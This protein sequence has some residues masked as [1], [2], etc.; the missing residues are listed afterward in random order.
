MKTFIA[1]FLVAIAFSDDPLSAVLR[2]PKATLKLYGDFKAMQHMRFSSSEDLMR[3]RL[4]KKNAHFVAASNEDAEDTAQYALNFF[5]AMTEDE[6]RQWTGVNVTNH[7]PND[8]V[9]PLLTSYLSAPDSRLWVNE[10]A[11]TAVKNQGSCGSCWTF[12][13][14]GGLETHY[15]VKAGRLRNFAEQEY[16]D[17]VY[18]GQ[19]N[20]CNGGWPDNAYYYS[21]NNGGRIA[22]TADYPYRALDGTC[23]ASSKPNSAI[24]YK[25]VGAS[26]IGTS[27]SDNIQALASGSLSMA[28]EVTSKFQ[29][30]SGGIIKDTTCTGRINHGVTGVGYTPTYV[31]VK[32]SWG[33]GWGDHGY[34]KFARHHDNCQ[35]FKYSSHAKL[36]STDLS[37][38]GTDDEATDYTPSDDDSSPQPTCKDQASGC[39]TYHCQYEDLAENYCQET[40]NR[41]PCASEI[42]SAIYSS[43]KNDVVM[44]PTFEG[45]TYRWL[46]NNSTYIAPEHS[47]LNFYSGGKV[48]QIKNLTFSDEASYTVYDVYNTEDREYFYLF[49]SASSTQ[50]C[51]VAGRVAQSAALYVLLPAQYAV[52]TRLEG[53][54]YVSLK[55]FLKFLTFSN[56]Q[57]LQIIDLRENDF[58]TY[59]AD[60]IS[61]EGWRYTFLY[62]LYQDREPPTP[63][64]TIKGQPGGRTQ[65]TATTVGTFRIISWFYF[66]RGSSQPTLVM[67]T[68]GKFQ[69]S[70]DG[71]SLTIINLETSLSG[72]YQAQIDYGYGSID[73]TFVYDLQIPEDERKVDEEVTVRPGQGVWITARWKQGSYSSVIW[74]RLTGGRWVRIVE[75]PREVEIRGNA[76]YIYKPSSFY[77]GLY[78]AEFMDVRG[79][80][81]KHVIIMVVVDDSP[82][83]TVQYSLVILGVEGPLLPHVPLASGDGGGDDSDSEV[84]F[85]C[86]PRPTTSGI[87]NTGPQPNQY[88]EH[89]EEYTDVELSSPEQSFNVSG[90]LIE[91]F[92]VPPATP[93]FEVAFLDNDASPEKHAFKVS[94]AKTF[95]VQWDKSST[96]E[97]FITHQTFK[98]IKCSCCADGL[99]MYMLS[100]AKDFPNAPVVPYFLGS[101]SNDQS[102]AD[103]RLTQYAGRSTN[104]DAITLVRGMERINVK[105]SL[106]GKESFQV[107]HT[108]GRT[109]YKET[110]PLEGDPANPEN[111]GDPNRQFFGSDIN[112][113]GIRNSIKNGINACIKDCQELKFPFFMKASLEAKPRVSQTVSGYD[114]DKGIDECDS[115][116]ESEDV[117]YTDE[118]DDFGPQYLTSAMG[119]M[120]VKTAEAIYFNGGKLTFGTK[121]R[122]S[123]FYSGYFSEK[124]SFVEF[125]D[126]V[127]M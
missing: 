123:R 7:L 111:S 126:S 14:V 88:H 9:P 48:M 23:Q 113:Q 74:Y 84:S 93:T 118:D 120:H 83:P 90:P 112:V 92:P 18:E 122:K 43:F 82:P 17:C 95:F 117:V 38:S 100:L 77:E 26:R 29:Q 107:A 76:I 6:K 127:K 70:E 36:E 37:D 81:L 21:A 41:C 45:T 4:F 19:K 63:R 75:T 39:H 119:L 125:N 108:R 124:S 51:G 44:S 65:L 57:T 31:L 99:I 71:R 86:S 69:L 50:S 102:H 58:G 62:G 101:D 59:K 53:N 85:S 33:S 12:A 49:V 60:V 32:N 96:Q 5:S 105:S 27:E 106:P 56:G 87:G 46:K 3:F 30:Y 40:C 10:G 20:G 68:D 110:V 104:L 80:I 91:N 79:V 22:S 115:D 103:A 61:Q 114:E 15:K 64:F 73:S 13:A 24:A 94:Y 78:R 16:L 109:V 98:D 11:V 8:D 1:L 66:Q 28:F 42:S 67:P 2:S 72:I 34:V 54:K 97:Q 25:I 55:N 89:C 47:R 116:I 35:L 121:S 52:W